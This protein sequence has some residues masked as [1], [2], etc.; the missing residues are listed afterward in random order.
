MPNVTTS[1]GVQYFTGPHLS[2]IETENQAYLDAILGPDRPTGVLAAT[3]IR[4]ARKDAG[5]VGVSGTMTV[6]RSRN[7]IPAGTT[8]TT[9]KVYSGNTAAVTPTNQWVCLIDD[10]TNRNVL[11][12]SAD[13]TTEAWGTDT[14]KVFTFTGGYT[15]TTAIRP[16]VGLVVVA[17]TMPNIMADVH[18]RGAITKVTP[19]M[20][21]TSTTGLTDP[22]SLGATAAALS[23]SISV[24]IYVELS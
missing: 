23:A 7:V 24:H 19:I 1:E 16:Y 14:E 15:T 2:S 5:T 17:G 20:C 11:V 10:D 18:G 8:I 13:K 3:G 4:N 21:G 6:A 22:A 9:A 12:K